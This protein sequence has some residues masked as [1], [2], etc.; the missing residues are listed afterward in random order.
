MK[1]NDIDMETLFAMVDVIGERFD[2]EKP[3]AI[4]MRSNEK[5]QRF[6][7]L[8]A[9]GI[10]K[11][12][13]Q[14]QQT[15][16]GSIDY[17]TFPYDLRKSRLETRSRARAVELPAGVLVCVT[18]NWRAKWEQWKEEYIGIYEIQ[19][20]DQAKYGREHEDL[21]LEDF[22]RTKANVIP[23]T[24]ILTWRWRGNDLYAQIEAQT[25]MVYV[26]L[27]MNEPIEYCK[28][29]STQALVGQVYEHLF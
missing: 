13:Q 20:E 24:S 7:L 18:K 4:D 22:L 16:Q 10:I 26:S 12:I 9:I 27:N 15:Q 29:F 28:S 11:E 6:D 1:D 8:K 17:G 23:N 3:F 5:K 25:K 2:N 14:P 21:I 19:N